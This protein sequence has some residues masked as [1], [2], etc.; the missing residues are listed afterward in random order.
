MCAWGEAGG[1]EGIFKFSGVGVGGDDEK[2]ERETGWQ[3]SLVSAGTSQGGGFMTCRQ[4]KRSTLFITLPGRRRFTTRVYYVA[5]PENGGWRRRLWRPRWQPMAARGR[6]NAW[7]A[8]TKAQADE[9][10]EE[11]GTDLMITGVADGVGGITWSGGRQGGSSGD[12]GKNAA[13]WLVSQAPRTDQTITKRWWMVFTPLFSLFFIDFLFSFLSL[14]LSFSFISC[15]VCAAFQPFFEFTNATPA[16]KWS[17]C[18]TFFFPNN[19]NRR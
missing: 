1:R 4:R 3:R 16:S 5:D 14:S 2:R 7:N 10:E 11:E 6:P 19:N 9:Y 8:Q 15:F 13:R 18:A 12:G 17:H